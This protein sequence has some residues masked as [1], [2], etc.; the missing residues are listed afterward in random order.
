MLI[1][2]TSMPLFNKRGRLKTGIHHLLLWPKRRADGSYPTKTPGKVPIV[3]RGDAGRLDNLRKKYLRFV[4]LAGVLESQLVKSGKCCRFLICI[5]SGL[6]MGV[7]QPLVRGL[8]DYGP[9]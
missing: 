9:R 6:F 8:V 2:G 1:G 7:F 5:I 3:E 4:I